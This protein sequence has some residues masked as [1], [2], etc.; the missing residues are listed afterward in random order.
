MDYSNSDGDREKQSNVR[1][2][3]ELK[4]SDTVEVRIESVRKGQVS[5]IGYKNQIDHSATV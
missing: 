3:S 5:I 1:E 4:L 2:I